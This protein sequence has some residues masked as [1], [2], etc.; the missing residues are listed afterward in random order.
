MSK[1]INSSVKKQFSSA[2]L[3]LVQD[4][5]QSDGEGGMERWMALAIY[6]LYSLLVLLNQFTFQIAPILRRPPRIHAFVHS[7]GLYY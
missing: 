1:N 4:V 7:Q 2:S 5:P 6:I 3:P